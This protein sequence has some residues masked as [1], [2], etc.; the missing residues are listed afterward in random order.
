MPFFIQQDG[1]LSVGPIPPNSVKLLV[2]HEGQIQEAYVQVT[3]RQYTGALHGKN[4]Q[5]L[6]TTH[7]VSPVSSVAVFN[8]HNQEVSV[9]Y[10]V[11][12]DNVRIESNVDLSLHTVKIN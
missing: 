4:V 6:H 9:V 2:L 1:S 10:T 5:I 7:G 11:D 8:R 3:K 12:N